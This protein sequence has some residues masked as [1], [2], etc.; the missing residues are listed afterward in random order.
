MGK[1]LQPNDG[2]VFG[3]SNSLGLFEKLKYDST[4]LRKNWNDYD[5]FNFFVTSWHLYHD[6]TKS[7]SLRAL[8]R[9]KRDS[10]KLPKE[11]KL[12]LNVVKELANGSKHFLLNQS[13]KSTEKRKIMEVHE[14]IEANPYSYFFHEDIPA[15]SVDEH[16]Y[17]SIRVLHNIIISYFD[18]VFDDSADATNFPN[19]IMEAILY[20]HVPSRKVGRPPEICCQN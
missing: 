5:A 3:I 2:A 20:C 4:N 17:F 9:V 7:D 19:H 16:W 6:W 11:I 15:V 14:G 18:W 12:V 10:N 1:K 13:Q 8:S